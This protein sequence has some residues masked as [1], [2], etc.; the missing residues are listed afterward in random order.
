MFEWIGV[1]RSVFEFGVVCAEFCFGCGFLVGVSVAC[2]FL[3]Y[4]LVV[5][6]D[7]MVFECCC[8]NG[9][10]LVVCGFLVVLDVVLEC[11]EK[12]LF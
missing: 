11:C 1:E 12:I 7:F 2:V 3:V 6:V 4:D 9:L 5:F 8:E 10:W